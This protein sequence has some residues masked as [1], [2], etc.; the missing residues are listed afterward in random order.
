MHNY[1]LSIMHK[2]VYLIEEADGSSCSK[3]DVD[4]EDDE[5]VAEPADPPKVTQQV[6]VGDTEHLERNCL[7]SEKDNDHLDQEGQGGG[8]DHVEGAVQDQVGHR[9]VPGVWNRNTRNRINPPHPFRGSILWNVG[10]L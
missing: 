7:K 2:S 10:M 1:P 9:G 4:P 3:D 6:E 5:I 8:E